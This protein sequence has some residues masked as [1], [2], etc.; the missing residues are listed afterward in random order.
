MPIIEIEMHLRDGLTLD[1]LKKRLAEGPDKVTYAEI[2]SAM[3]CHPL[4]ARNII[5][6][7]KGAGLIEVVSDYRPGGYTYRV[8]G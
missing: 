6:R 1:W 5:N 4:T 3:K 8:K 7:L 2:A